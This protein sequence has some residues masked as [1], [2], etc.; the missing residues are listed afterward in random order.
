MRFPPRRAAVVPALILVFSAALAGCTGMGSSKPV[1]YEPEAFRSTDTHTRSFAATEAQTCE[2]ARR[3]LL[4]QGYMISN[5]AADGV[6]GRK[7]FQPASE[8]HVEVE[9]RVVCAREASR[10]DGGLSSIAFASALQDRYAVKKVNNAASVGVGA[11]GS[12]SLPFSSSDDAM[13]KVASETLTDDRLYDRFFSLIERFLPEAMSMIPAA[14]AA[15]AATAAAPA[16]TPAA[17][18]QAT[19]AATPAAPTSPANL[20]TPAADK[21]GSEKSGKAG[22]ANGDVSAPVIDASSNR[23]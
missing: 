21:V 8:V 3:A 22:T 17:A 2:A 9:F 13:V 15:P 5:A 7:S 23:G 14:P 11:I 20:P 12:L 1:T 16:T 10:K 4:S 19:P 6:T 18:A